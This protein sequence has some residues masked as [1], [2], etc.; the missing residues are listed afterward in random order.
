M[1]LFKYLCMLILTASTQVSAQ[2]QNSVCGYIEDKQLTIPSYKFEVSVFHDPKVVLGNLSMVGT[3]EITEPIWVKN[4]LLDMDPYWSNVYHNISIPVTYDAKQGV[5]ISQELAKIAI[6][7]RKKHAGWRSKPDCWD[8]VQKLT[9][10]FT[11]DD[12]KTAGFVFF[13]PNRPITQ[14]SLPDN[15]DV[16]HLM[17]GNT[18]RLGPR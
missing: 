4:G 15:I 16:I 17:I 13:F 6:A 11:T 18:L 2:D 5:Y 10:D 14:I 12:G 8:R 1:R 3:L 9:F 7:H